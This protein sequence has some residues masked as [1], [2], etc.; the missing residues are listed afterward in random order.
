[1]MVRRCPRTAYA[2]FT[3]IGAYG[4]AGLY[5]PR[6]TWI[7]ARPVAAL[8]I[9]LMPMSAYLD[10]Y[11]GFPARRITAHTAAMT[12]TWIW[13]PVDP[14]RLWSMNPAHGLSISDRGTGPVSV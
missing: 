9:L 6:K 11:L 3:G 2:C 4:L 7:R 14:P 10:V 12:K 5:L 8:A 13:K 1:M